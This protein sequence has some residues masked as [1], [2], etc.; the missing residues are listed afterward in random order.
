MTNTN[1]TDLIGSDGLPVEHQN[2]IKKIAGQMIPAS[3]EFQLPGADDHDIITPILRRLSRQPS[4]VAQIYHSVD[5]ASLA[6][7]QQPFTEI[8]DEDVDRLMAEFRIQHE[9]LAASLMV[10]VVACYY[11]D[12]RV[13]DSIEHEAR[14]PF[15]LGHKLQQG[16][17]NL[18]EPVKARAKFYRKTEA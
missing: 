4:L 13:L 15:P 6:H 12:K 1:P 14:P 18:L 10:T 2:C 9:S 7:Y 3:T 17:W 5:N 8:N 11:E 16:N